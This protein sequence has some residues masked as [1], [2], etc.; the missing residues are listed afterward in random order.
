MANPDLL[1]RAKTVTLIS[2]RAG[3]TNASDGPP[4]VGTS[5]VMPL[6]GREVELLI[7]LD[8]YYD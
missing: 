2:E 7:H 8:H 1:L 3:R 4:P 6:E 5:M